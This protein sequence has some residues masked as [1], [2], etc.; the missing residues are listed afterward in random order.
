MYFTESSDENT[1]S[2]SLKHDDRGSPRRFADKGRVIESAASWE[3]PVDA[4][5]VYLFTACIQLEEV[6]F[7]RDKKSRA[8]Y[9]RL[10]QAWLVHAYNPNTQEDETGGL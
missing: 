10:G 8:I 2:L 9:F 6:I 5:L 1:I 7:C 4:Q 3:W